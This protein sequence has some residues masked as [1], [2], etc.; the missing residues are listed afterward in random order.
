MD[1][2][3]AEGNHMCG[4]Q[5]LQKAGWQEGLGL[6]AHGQGRLNPIP[7]WLQAGRTG[8]GMASAQPAAAPQPRTRSQAAATQLQQSAADGRP[9]EQ[10]QAVLPL[11]Q[12]EKASSS[13]QGRSK[14]PKRAWRQ[15]RREIRLKIIKEPC[16]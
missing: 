3:H 12:A 11:G 10:P 15:V 16:N 7:A 1:R 5:L 4:L 6:G 8:I 13:T 14:A 2:R 9:Q